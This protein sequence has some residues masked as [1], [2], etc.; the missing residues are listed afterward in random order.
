MDEHLLKLL[1]LPHGPVEGKKKGGREG[2]E[3]REREEGRKRKRK[4]AGPQH[5]EPLGECPVTLSASASLA[6]GI[7]L[8]DEA[9]SKFVLL[10][11]RG[12]PGGC[13]R[14][15]LVLLTHS[16]NPGGAAF[17]VYAGS[18]T[19]PELYIPAEFG[20]PMVVPFPPAPP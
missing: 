18:Q 20:V 6:W 15:V 1:M 17:Q 2:K 7:P 5:P 12:H 14:G 8:P 9:E 11:V 3:K 10:H 13:P 16:L 19:R 4:G